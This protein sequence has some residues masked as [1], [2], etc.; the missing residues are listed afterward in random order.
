M[1]PRHSSKNPYIKTTR[2]VKTLNS[3]LRFNLQKMKASILFAFF[4]LAVVA[5]MTTSA[6]KAE[7]N[8]QEQELVNVEEYHGGRFRR[9][10]CSIG[11]GSGLCNLHC[12]EMGKSGGHC[13][14]FTCV[15]RN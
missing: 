9:F 6:E 2:Q 8:E 15:C 1:L 11:V 3:E 4:C 13:D 7:V 12:K 5:V 10:T 14:G